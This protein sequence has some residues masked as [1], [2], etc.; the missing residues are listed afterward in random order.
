[1]ST[2]IRK[3]TQLLSKLPGVG[4][5]TAQRFVIALATSPRSAIELAEALRDLADNVVPCADCNNLTDRNLDA[6]GATQCA[7]CSDT[8]RDTGTLCV[9]SRLQDLLAFERSAAMRG[10]Y[11]ILGKLLSPLEGIGPEALPV[12][13]LRALI[14]RLGVREVILATPANMEGEAT[15]LFLK[16]ELGP[17]FAGTFTRLATG[18]AH[19]ADLEFAD[20]ITLG[21][22]L[23]GRKTL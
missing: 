9:V 23:E 20:A 6:P 16:R 7:I 15:A 13:P 18:I 17:D 2:R 12:A 1:V 3:V 19:G 5:K 8:R 14:A 11:F 10:R 4:E 21:R 22:A